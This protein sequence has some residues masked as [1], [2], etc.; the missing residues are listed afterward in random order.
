MKV[1]MQIKLY[2]MLI[3]FTQLSYCFIDNILRKRQYGAVRFINSFTC[4]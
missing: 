2:I 1:L 3:V 4:S